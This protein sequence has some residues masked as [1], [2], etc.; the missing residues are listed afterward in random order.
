MRNK[1]WERDFFRTI[2]KRAKP[3]RNLDEKK[4]QGNNFYG[5]P[6]LQII[7]LPPSPTFQ[8]LLLC[9]LM[10]PQ[11]PPTSPF[12]YPLTLLFHIPTHPLSSHHRHSTSFHSVT[13]LLT[14]L[15]YSRSFTSHPFFHPLL[16]LTTYISIILS[17]LTFPFSLP[18]LPPNHSIILSPFYPLIVLLRRI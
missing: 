2:E 14:Y 11:S 12:I 5:L 18:S 15:L 10:Q 9:P 16:H 13:H 17:P 6:L 8:P 7:N 4:K 1:S 3:K